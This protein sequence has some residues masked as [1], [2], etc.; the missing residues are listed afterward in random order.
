MDQDLTR[1]NHRSYAVLSGEGIVLAKL[2]AASGAL[3]ATQG[4][5]SV[6]SEVLVRNLCSYL[7]SCFSCGNKTSLLD[8]LSYP[9]RI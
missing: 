4:K 8:L 6:Y 2:E 7:L 3:N 5:L 9:P 1:S